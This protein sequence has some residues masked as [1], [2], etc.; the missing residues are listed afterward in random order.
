MSS[1][2]LSLL[3]LGTSSTQAFALVESSNLA[4]C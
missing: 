1:G 3:W 2:T 4:V